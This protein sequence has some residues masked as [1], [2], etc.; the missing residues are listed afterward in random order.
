MN[1][2]SPARIVI[3]GASGGWEPHW[4]A[5]TPHRGERLSCGGV[6]ARLAAV[7]ATC[8]EAGATVVLRQ[9]NLTDSHAAIA[10]IEDDDDAGAITLALLVVGTA[11]DGRFPRTHRYRR[12][13]QQYGAPAVPDP[14]RRCGGAYRRGDGT[15]ARARDLS[16]AVRR[17]ALVRSVAATAAARPPAY[18]AHPAR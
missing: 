5:I 15:G 11:R 4:R 10:A 18:R 6:T 3:T 9:L 17:A 12:R 16:L 1:K 2:V 14:A 7:E 13:P 8:S